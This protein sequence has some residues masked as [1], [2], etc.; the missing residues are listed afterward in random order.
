MENWKEDSCCV[1]LKNDTDFLEDMC[2]ECE[3]I[4]TERQLQETY[5]DVKEK[6]NMNFGHACD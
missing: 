2:L 4:I 3:D 5:V 6:I 1:C